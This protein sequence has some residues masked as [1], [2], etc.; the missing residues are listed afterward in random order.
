MG[1]NAARRVHV[2]VDQVSLRG[3]SAIDREHVERAIRRHVLERLNAG[4]ARVGSRRVS[5]GS[6]PVADGIGVAVATAVEKVCR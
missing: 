3:V 2:H 5:N 6:E 1:V 4:G